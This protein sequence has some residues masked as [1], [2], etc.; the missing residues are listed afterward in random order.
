M[1]IINQGWFHSS[2]NKSIK[3]LKKFFQQPVDRSTIKYFSLICC[4]G[5]G[6]NILLTGY[7]PHSGFAPGQFV[8]VKASIKNLSKIEYHEVKIKLIQMTE[9]RSS[10][11]RPKSNYEKIVV[12]L[13]RFDIVDQLPERE[14]NCNLS[15]PPLPPSSFSTC[16]I[17]EISYLVEIQLKTKG[18]HTNMF[19]RLPITI[20]TVPLF[21]GAA[22]EYSIVTSQPLSL[23]RGVNGNQFDGL[24]LTGKIYI[25]KLNVVNL[26][27][28]ILIKNS[29]LSTA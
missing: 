21:L 10:N 2:L 22:P 25:R 1:K 12:T 11:P 23:Q 3:S 9:F 20:G 27:F 17:I 6:G 28:K 14:L 24:L 18:I 7:I 8:P 4:C 26:F 29:L 16:N 15:I 13:K 5:D 19:V